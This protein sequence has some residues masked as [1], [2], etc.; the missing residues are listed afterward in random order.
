LLK[1]L[2]EK[3]N[4][5]TKFQVPGDSLPSTALEAPFVIS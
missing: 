5:P 3:V 2:E 4:R 1:D